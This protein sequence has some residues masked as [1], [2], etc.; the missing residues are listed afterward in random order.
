MQDRKPG[1][2]YNS[3]LRLNER[4][5]VQVKKKTQKNTGDIDDA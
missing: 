5:T 3:V 1:T 4:V 2:E